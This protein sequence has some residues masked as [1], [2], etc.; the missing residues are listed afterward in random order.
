MF[1]M[2]LNLGIGTNNTSEYNAFILC[3]ILSKILKLRKIAV[4]SDSELLVGQ[5]KGLKKVSS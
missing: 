3:L 5:V 4:Y 1:G 2:N